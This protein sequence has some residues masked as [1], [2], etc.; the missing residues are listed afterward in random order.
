MGGDEIRAKLRYDAETVVTER[1]DNRAPPESISISDCHYHIHELEVHQVELELQNE[2]LREVKS[3]LEL[4]RD[5]YQ[6]LYDYAPISYLT[7]TYQG[8]IKSI[9]L[10]GAA[11]LRRERAILLNKPLA[12]FIAKS[13]FPIFYQHVADALAND[14]RHTCEVGLVSKGVSDTF[15]RLDS[16]GAVMG[17][18]EKVIKVA[19]SDITERRKLDD[20]L[21]K[22]KDAAE[23]AREAM[24]NFIA[25][26]SHEILDLSK[27]Q[28]GHFAIQK[29]CLIFMNYSLTQSSSLRTQQSQRILV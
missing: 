21:R 19:I 29:R 4:S 9:N 12:S 5:Q 3:D 7:L 10:T 22:A 15:I 24:A 16:I 14:R 27:L 17:G 11:L 23:M 25:N 18:G 28:S 2:E 6:E 13:C 26:M 1:R 8:L 20:E